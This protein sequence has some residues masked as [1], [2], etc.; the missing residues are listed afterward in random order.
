MDAETTATHRASSNQGTKRCL[1]PAL[2]QLFPNTDSVPRVLTIVKPGTLG[3][4]KQ[5][6]Y[7][8][9]DRSVSRRHLEVVPTTN[10]LNLR[11]LESRHGSAVDGETLGQAVATVGSIV[12]IGETLHLV[13]RDG[14]TQAAA[15]RVLPGRHL[16]LPEQRL[17]A[18]PT[19]AAVWDQAALI[20][21][22]T[23]SVLLEGETGTGKEVVA[24]IVHQARGRELPFV[25]VNLAAIPEGLFE[26]ELFGHERGAFTGASNARKGAF[27]EASG[28]VLF[29]DEVGDLRTDLQVKLL[30]ALELSR[31]RPLGAATDVPVDLTIVAATSVDLGRACTEG[32]FRQDLFYRL[33]GMRLRVPPLR[34]RREDILRLAT[35]H[36]AQ[37]D[38]QLT[39]NS[40]AAERLLLA[41]WE[42]NVRQLRYA[43]NHAIAKTASAGRTEIEGD[44]LPRFDVHAEKRGEITAESLDG[45]L[46]RTRGN[47]SE[48]ARVLGI[49]RTTLY[50]HCRKF[51]LDP[52]SLRARTDPPEPHG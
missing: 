42:G 2:V 49:S 15:P 36:L 27:R 40:E 44:D 37:R 22:H 33:A 24:R 18:G 21:R 9:A 46:R 38:G 3:R 13:V 32:R 7:T 47:A 19:L 50:A 1:E 48:A 30:R 20:A 45:V 26:A 43:L 51:D 14:G 25:G 8:V 17:I 5:A 28:G 10:G 31:V 6:D 12:R 41:E 39:L 23:A 11:D 4:G 35:S 52:S 34:E 29:L 16:D